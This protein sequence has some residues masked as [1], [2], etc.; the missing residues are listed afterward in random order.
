MVLPLQEVTTQASALSGLALVILL[1][2]RHVLQPRL[3]ENQRLAFDVAVLPLLS[4]L[5]IFVVADFL[6]ALP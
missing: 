6:G 5:A 1:L 3:T 2:I 4:V